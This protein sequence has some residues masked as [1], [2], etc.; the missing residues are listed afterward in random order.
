MIV[1]ELIKYLS[2]DNCHINIKLPNDNYVPSHFHITEV[3]LVDKT[4]IDCG[5]TLR[6][7]KTCLLQVWTAND[8]DHRIDSN[9]LLKI[10]QYVESL[11]LNDLEV[12]IEYGENTVSQY[13]LK[14]VVHN[15]KYGNVLW[16]YLANKKTDCLAPDKCGVNQC[17]GT[18]CC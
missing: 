17:C 11:N 5:G 9:K 8:T 16:F 4:F 12:E 2:D 10:L 15:I 1:K 18:N 3:G 6:S 13:S 14:E 7:S